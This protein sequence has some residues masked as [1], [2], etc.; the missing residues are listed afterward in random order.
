MMSITAWVVVSLAGLVFFYL[1]AGV[2]VVR[3][4]SRGLV[5]RFGKYRRLAE[6]GFHWIAPLV[7]RMFLV[8]VAEVMVNAERQEIVR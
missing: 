4:K 2:R 8:D 7:E 5:Q 6:P 3:P 1:L